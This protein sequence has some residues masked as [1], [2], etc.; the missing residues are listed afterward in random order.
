[1]TYCLTAPT[2]LQGHIDLPAS[3]SLSNRALILSALTQGAGKLTNLS[4][5]DDTRVMIEA[6][7]AG[8][9]D[10]N[11][12]AAGTAMR[13]LTAYLSLQPGQWTL[14]GTERMK[15]RPISLLVEALRSLG[16][17][18]EYLEKEGYPPLV[19]NGGSLQGGTIT[20]DGGI[21]SQYLSALMMV[22]PRMNK[23]LTL[24]IK[25]KLISQPYARMTL[26]M[27]TAYG[28]NAT[29]QDNQIILP[30]GAYRAIDYHVEADWSAASYWY[31]LLSL[32]PSGELILHALEADSLQGDAAIVNYF[33]PLG[34]ATTWIEGGV[35]LTKTKVE[36]SRFE[37]D[38]S[39]QPDLAQTL[40]VT[41]AA[42]DIPFC[43]KGL[44]SLKIKETDRIAA[45]L[46]EAA[47][48]GYVFEETP[49]NGLSWT[50]KRCTPEAEPVIATYEDHRM[51]LSFAPFA[52]KQKG[53]KIAHPAVVSKSYPAFWNALEAVGFSVEHL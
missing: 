42:L 34:V 43:L 39:N 12:G 41:C 16:A 15:N 4:D 45:L 32:A 28:I 3:K 7:Q 29:W 38:L 18:I 35:R 19:I 53:L 25:G 31:E 36:T 20:I 52:F 33:K 9:H 23:G 6:L 1:M 26:R 11:I 37:A 49:A 10:L 5:C 14:T 22:G 51:A 44:G 50:G 40:A 21:S 47:K 27:M 8:K 17:S 13:F 2:N 30:A 24:T 46:T 48:L